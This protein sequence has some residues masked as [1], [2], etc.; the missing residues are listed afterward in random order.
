[1]IE[2]KKLI[3]HLYNN[4]GIINLIIGISF[5]IFG[6]FNIGILPQFYEAQSGSIGFDSSFMILV[7]TALW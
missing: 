7:N 4:I 3:I 1:M 6:I 5:L 2:Q